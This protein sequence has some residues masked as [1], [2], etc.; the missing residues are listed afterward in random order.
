[1]PAAVVFRQ[2]DR[3]QSCAVV[4]A[5]FLARQRVVSGRNQISSFYVPG[6]MPNLI[7]CICP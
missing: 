2:G 3:P 1:M 4:M 7:P 5:G 6:D